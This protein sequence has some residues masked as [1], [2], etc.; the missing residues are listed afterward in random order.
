MGAILTQRY[1]QTTH[2]NSLPSQDPHQ[3]SSPGD[4]HPHLKMLDVLHEA[5]ERLQ[6]PTELIN[7]LVSSISFLPLSPFSWNFTSP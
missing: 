6:L 5:W 4:R 1:P 3:L 2:G 7:S